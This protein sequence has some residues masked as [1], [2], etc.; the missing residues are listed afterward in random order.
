MEAWKLVCRSRSLIVWEMRRALSSWARLLEGIRVMFYFYFHFWFAFWYVKA[1]ECII[2]REKCHNT[3]S[4]SSSGS[5]SGSKEQQHQK[6]KY[7]TSIIRFYIR[8][9][10][11]GNQK[12]KNVNT[13]RV[14]LTEECASTHSWQ[15]SDLTVINSVTY[16]MYLYIYTK[17]IR[18][19]YPASSHLNHF[20]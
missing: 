10:T 14:Y 7:K 8:I 17:S 15:Q 4:V 5:K 20:V 13:F 18:N 3:N 9:F 12:K 1:V 6:L 19:I 2:F 11:S 16:Q